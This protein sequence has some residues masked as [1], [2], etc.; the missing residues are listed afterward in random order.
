MIATAGR[1][2][3]RGFRSQPG[4]VAPWNGNSIRS[5]GGSSMGAAEP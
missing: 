3:S 2:T 5:I 4:I 1:M